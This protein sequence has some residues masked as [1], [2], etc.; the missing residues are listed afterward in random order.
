MKPRRIS[1]LC[2]LAA[3]LLV[4]LGARDAVAQTSPPDTI[5]ACYV[6]AT[7]TIYRIG[8]PGLPS[9]CLSRE[10]VEF[11]WNRVAPA[12]PQG[13]A[14]P[15]GPKGDKGDPGPQGVQGPPGPQGPAGAGRSA[16][17]SGTAG[18]AGAS[19]PTGPQ[20]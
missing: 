20:G 16:G 1:L 3:A 10:H 6:P 7:G 9:T 17:T 18:T 13:P 4:G 12:G 11:W 5:R 2:A 15:A 14:G 19:G 8:V